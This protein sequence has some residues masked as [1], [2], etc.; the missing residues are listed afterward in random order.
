MSLGLKLIG[1]QDS[2]WPVFLAALANAGLP[3]DDLL[4]P[5]QRFYAL[6]DDEIVGFGGYQLL[7]R[8]ALL[9]SV[10]VLP[11]RRNRD[12]GR[13][14]TSAL[15]NRL[16]IEGC[17]RAW[18][19]TTGASEFFERFGF[20]AQPRSAAPLKVASTREFAALCPASAVLMCQSL[21]GH[22]QGYEARESLHNE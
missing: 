2:S 1:W 9:R 14:L 22:R 6:T 12:Y 5:G 18:L 16:R 21:V 13:Q 20:I 3:T 4:E 8:D 7:G 17:D 10:I 11:D 19:L 15:L